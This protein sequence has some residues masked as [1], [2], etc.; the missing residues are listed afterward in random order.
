MSYLN[1]TLTSSS[2]ATNANWIISLNDVNEYLSTTSSSASLSTFYSNC[3]SRVSDQIEA[4]CQLPIASQSFR[5]LYSGNGTNELFLNNYPIVSVSS[6]KYRNN[7]TENWQ[8][9]ISS[10]SISGNCIIHPYKLELYNYYFTCGSQNIE[11]VYNAGFTNI[12][13]D[14]KQVAIEMCA[15][16]YKESS[17]SKSG[18][19]SRLGISTINSGSTNFGTSYLSL[20]E[21]H[22]KI[23]DKY[24]KI[25]V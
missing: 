21:R 18:D 17:F 2:T 24:R 11:V 9:I 10:G 3:I 16:I 22:E 15:I 20:D 4:Y 1:D 12:P 13:N 6:L 25:N 5:G 8:S 23:L 14:I 19:G 7:P